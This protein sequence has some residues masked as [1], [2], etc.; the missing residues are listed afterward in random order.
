MG[1]RPQATGV[2]DELVAAIHN[3]H[4]YYGKTFGGLSHNEA[5]RRGDIE[6]EAE[7]AVPHME[8]A[9]ICHLVPMIED[10][11][12]I[13]AAV[14]AAWHIDCSPPGGERVNLSGFC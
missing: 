2:D 11:D 4:A 10:G 7:A 3:V 1:H 6:A 12:G 8:R 13:P 14:V 9:D 5:S